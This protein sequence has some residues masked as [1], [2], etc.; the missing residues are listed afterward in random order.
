MKRTL[1]ILLIFLVTPL[2]THGVCYS[3]EHWIDIQNFNPKPGERVTIFACSG[4]EFPKSSQILSPRVFEGMRITRP[5]GSERVL[6][7]RP[8]E[9][10]K[11]LV[12][13][14]TPDHE[15]TYV[16]LF[17]LRKPPAN[18]VI[19]VAKALFSVGRKT[20]TEHRYGTGLEFAVEESPLRIRVLE[21]GVPVSLTVSVSIDGRKNFFLK[22]ARDGTV[23]IKTDQSGRY[24]LTANRMGKG[25]SL[26]FYIPEAKR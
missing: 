5:D 8:D 21:D 26:T 10:S 24:L 12:T 6:E 19:Y 4:H 2:M 17:T 25:A 7:S 15:G 11:A 1:T 9:V 14:F 18:Q 22:S 20:P 3:H 23:P 13:E 16:V